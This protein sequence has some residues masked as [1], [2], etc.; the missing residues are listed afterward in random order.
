M[1]FVGLTQ[2][3]SMARTRHK[4]LALCFPYN[5]DQA[6]VIIP[7]EKNKHEVDDTLFHELFIFFG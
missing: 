1:F 5:P 4:Y 6:M 7:K 3:A 2:T